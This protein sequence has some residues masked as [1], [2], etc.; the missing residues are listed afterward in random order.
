MVKV[1]ERPEKVVLCKDPGVATESGTTPWDG[2]HSFF[3]WEKVPYR[4]EK[5]VER[6]DLHSTVVSV[7]TSSEGIFLVE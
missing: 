5:G 7:D 4:P 1:A 2:K 6:K 3:D